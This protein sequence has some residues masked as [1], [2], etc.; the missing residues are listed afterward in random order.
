MKQV[1][2][3]QSFSA[4]MAQLQGMSEKE[5]ALQPFSEGEIDLLKSTIE[6]P[7]YYT[8]LRQYNG[9][10]PGLFYA[11]ALGGTRGVQLPGCVE[12]DPMVV[13]VHTDLPDHIVGDPGAVIHEGV[14]NVHLLVIAV[15]N[16]P[17]RMIYAGPVLSHY[18]FEELGVNR[19]SDADWKSKL[20]S[21]QKPPSPEWTRPYLISSP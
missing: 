16:G 18:E 1:S 20:S 6:Q 10:Y 13:D 4:C 3:L 12:W 19:L 7:Q 11:N 14:G 21:G 2:F 17:D 9:W 15:D 8:G 5:L